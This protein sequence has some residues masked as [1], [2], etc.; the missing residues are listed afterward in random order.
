MNQQQITT[1]SFDNGAVGHGIAAFAETVRHAK[2]IEAVEEELEIRLRSIGVDHYSCCSGAEPGGRVRAKWLRGKCK[3]EW[4]DRYIQQDH[5][6]RDQMVRYGMISL[7]PTTWGRF[8]SEVE[9]S[10]GQKLIFDEAREF[11]LRDGFFLPIHQLDGSMYI[12]TMKVADPFEPDEQLFAT[13]HMLGLYYGLAVRKLCFGPEA[14]PKPQ[15]EKTPVL[16]GR[17]RECLQWVRAGKTDWEIGQI[18][19]ISQRTV[20]EHLELARRRLGVATRTQA[21]IEAISRGLI[22][23]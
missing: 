3:R 12:V 22:H 7:E 2:S 16:T 5:T 13:L 14:T 23:L 18:L 21:V 1:R 4:N 17:Q 15:A 11:G 9:Q 10:D 19:G 8:A 6:H 20:V